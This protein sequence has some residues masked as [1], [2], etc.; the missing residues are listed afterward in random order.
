M[1]SV[2]RKSFCHLLSQG[3]SWKRN[4][5]GNGSFY[6]CQVI[7]GTKCSTHPC[8]ALYFNTTR[9]EKSK[10]QTFPETVLSSSSSSCHCLLCLADVAVTRSVRSMP[11]RPAG[12]TS[13]TP[14]SVQR[15]KQNQYTVRKRR[16]T[17][18]GET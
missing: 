4:D 12:A 17:E 1:T 10:R 16:R 5:L 11:S 14:H 15:E 13:P 8:I 18:R 2:N 7:K 3:M 6:H 9:A